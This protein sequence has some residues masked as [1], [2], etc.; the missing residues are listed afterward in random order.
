MRAS[1][2]AKISPPT[3][4]PALLADAAFGT[5][6]L[7]NH[8][9]SI[10]PDGVSYISIA[11]KYLDGNFGD[12]IN[13]YSGPLLPWLLVPFLA[14]GIA[15]IVAPKVVLLIT[16][17]MT[18]IGA[19]L[20]SHRFEMPESVRNILMVSLVPVTCYFA[21]FRMTPD[22]L[23][24]TT[25]VFYLAF[26]FDPIYR[27][28]AGYGWLCGAMGCLSYLAKGFGFPF[29]LVHFL[30]FNGLH[31]VSCGTSLEKRT[32]LRNCVSGLVVFSMLSGVWV[33]LIS[34]KYDEVTFSTSA[35][36]NYDLLD[37][38]E[39]AFEGRLIEPPN[40]TAVSY[41][42]D[43]YLALRAGRETQPFPPQADGESQARAV[44][45]VRI[46]T[47]RWR[48]TPLVTYRTLQSFF[49]FSVL[50]ILAAA[51][52]SLLRLRGH[53]ILMY[54]LLTLAV[55]SGGYMLILIEPRYLWIDLILLMMMGTHLLAG[56]LQLKK[57]TWRRTGSWLLLVVFVGSYSISP[58]GYL[59]RGNPGKGAFDLSQR[60]KTFNIRGRV[61]SDINWAG[62][63]Y[64][65]FYDG[66]S[67]YGMTGTEGTGRDPRSELLEHDIDYYFVWD[68][69]NGFVPDGRELTNDRDRPRIYSL[70]DTD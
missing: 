60:L 31:Y 28:N 67:Y 52:T 54:A 48:W 47:S 55:Y 27:E 29:F 56:P 46:A 35:A 6:F 69:Q 1:R 61:A 66:V 22:L 57:A 3:L 45:P 34:R 43:P 49:P 30:I 26:I 40:E 13:G 18:I 70:K 16:G 32:V 17:M 11:Q 41:W 33:L 68:S 15:L 19:G 64:E 25:L 65:A 14:V 39:Y 10:S 5:F 4:I 2:I 12:A 62:T 50:V 7:R 20:L 58:M 44:D 21:L 63:L 37:A 8:W 24:A 51:V 38:G 53:R 36:V 59:N 23:I 9:Y 42:E